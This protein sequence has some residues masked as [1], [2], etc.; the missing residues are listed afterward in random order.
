MFYIWQECTQ[1]VILY[2]LFMLPATR[3]WY[4]TPGRSYSVGFSGRERLA[5]QLKTAR[6]IQQS[7]QTT[8]PIIHLIDPPAVEELTNDHT[9]FSPQHTIKS[10]ISL[11]GRGSHTG[12]VSLYCSALRSSPVI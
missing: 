1:V 11:E 9:F 10:W 7:I 2:D 8:S 6:N 3:G 4:G 5:Q 12:A